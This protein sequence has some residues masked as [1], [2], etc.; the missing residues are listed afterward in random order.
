MT[1]RLLVL[2][3][4]VA[5]STPAFAQTRIATLQ[6][7][8][9]VGATALSPGGDQVA[10]RV[11]K[12]RVVV[13]SLPDG[14]LLQ[15]LKVPQPPAA[16][17]FGPADQIIVALADGAIEVRAIASG[18][19]VRRMDATVRQSVLAVSADG[20]LLASTGTEQIRLW[21]AS[22]KLLRTF[23]HEF[24]GVGSLAFS[25]DGTLLASA[26]DD[27]EVHLWDVSTGQRKISLPDRLLST[28]AVTFTADG[29]NLAIGGASGAIEIVDV[30][31]GSIARRLRAEKYAVASITLSPDGRSIGASYFD[32]D[33]MMRAA[34]LAV[35]ELASGRLS[36]RVTSPGGPAM[37]AGFTRDGL[38]LYVT[39]KG[40][41]LTVWTAPASASSSGT[42]QSKSAPK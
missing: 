25:P 3:A 6:A 38:L 8:A 21:D 5:A 15:D 32:V 41:E 13:W 40:P 37:A 24:G 1:S 22:G 7:A 27:T 34:P 2:I 23:G 28:F 14:K 36:R 12:D 30:K 33:G 31:T 19:L 4:A 16:V 26:G 42:A 17:L 29:R 10:A 20:R 11:G 39:T 9:D 18:A 35:L